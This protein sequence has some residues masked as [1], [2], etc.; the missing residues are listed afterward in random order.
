MKKIPLLIATV[1]GAVLLLGAGGAGAWWY[2]RPQTGAAHQEAP[3]EP[4]KTVY[5][6][7]SLDKVIVMLRGAEGKPLSNYLAVDLVLKTSAEQEKATKEHL[8]LLRSVTV[9]ALSSY[10]LAS[11]GQMSI[12]QFTADINRAFKESYAHDRREQPF[13]EAM[14]GKLII[15]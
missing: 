1:V 13:A 15:E 14:I 8:P 5:K 4:D 6:Y 12:D 10:T 2:M 7:V 9:K 3:P 11:A